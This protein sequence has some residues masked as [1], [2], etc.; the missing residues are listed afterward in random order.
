LE[1]CPQIVRSLVRFPQ[2]SLANTQLNH[3]RVRINYRHTTMLCTA[4]PKLRL[5]KMRRTRIVAWRTRTAEMRLSL[6]TRTRMSVK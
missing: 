2:Y 3:D 4:L 6:R 5:I 1:P